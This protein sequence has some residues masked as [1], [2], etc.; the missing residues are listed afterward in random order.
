MS[1][2]GNYKFNVPD[3]ETQQIAFF[4]TAREDSVNKQGENPLVAVA[5]RLKIM[6]DRKAE[7][8]QIVFRPPAFPVRKHGT[9]WAISPEA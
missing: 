4:K 2:K 5:L 7:A 6:N 8:E 3:V 1:G 9:V